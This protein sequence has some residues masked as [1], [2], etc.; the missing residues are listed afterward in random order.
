[1]YTSFLSLLVKRRSIRKYKDKAVP[2]D[3]R[4]KILQAALLAPSSRGLEPVSLLI[5]DDRQV[6]EQM[7]L[8]K[9]HGSTFVKDAPLAIVV[10]GQPQKS[11][12]WVED[13]SIVS[14]VLQL[15][16]ETHGLSSCWVQIRERLHTK[17]ISSEAYLRN[18]L[19]IPGSLSIESIIVLGYADEQKPPHDI[20]KL[21]YSRIH[22]ESYGL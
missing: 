13:A 18:L 22:H 2:V 16:A 15:A 17:G 21:D 10:I 9:Q 3:I 1:M 4:D 7:A 5:I 20:S 14:I 19:S 8:A 12:V 6:L 11:D